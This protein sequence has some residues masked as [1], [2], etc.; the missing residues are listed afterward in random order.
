MAIPFF[1]KQ[2]KQNESNENSIIASS[3]HL[4][5]LS[6][7]DI[8][9]FDIL[10]SL[11]N[12]YTS[13]YY[14]NLETGQAAVVSFDDRNMQYM[15]RMYV[16]WMIIRDSML[17]R[18]FRLRIIRNSLKWSVLKICVTRCPVRLSSHIVL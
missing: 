11:V 14:A 3:S 9:N 1:K 6:G 4:S 5:K 7:L 16:C 18:G 10:K 15:M 2:E 12:D 17:T 13:V 8:T